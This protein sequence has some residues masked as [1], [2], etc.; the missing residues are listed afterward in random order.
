MSLRQ[1]K[2]HRSA[3]NSEVLCTLKCRLGLIFLWYSLCVAMVTV[4]FQ[5]AGKNMNARLTWGIRKLFLQRVEHIGADG[6]YTGEV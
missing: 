5:N 2:S 1:Q 4:H 6:S 3:A